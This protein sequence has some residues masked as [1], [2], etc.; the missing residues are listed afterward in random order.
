M[1]FLL[2]NYDSFTFNLYQALSEL[3][4]KVEVR[5]NDQV[6][7]E[8]DP[9]DRAAVLEAIATTRRLRAQLAVTIPDRYKGITRPAR[10][11]LVPRPAAGG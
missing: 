7:E 2:D 1:I 8:L 4:A 3:G 9:G 10:P 11:T 5:R 6:I